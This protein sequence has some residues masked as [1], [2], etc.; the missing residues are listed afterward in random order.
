MQTNL[1]GD[2][3]FIELIVQEVI[4]RVKRYYN[5]GLLI[6]PTVHKNMAEE[7]IRLISSL[8]EPSM[9]DLII[10]KEFDTE[11]LDVFVKAGIY[12][13]KQIPHTEDLDFDQ[14]N[15]VVVL[16]IDAALIREVK[17]LRPYTLAGRVLLKSL[18]LE[19][20]IHILMSPLDLIRNKKS[21]SKFDSVVMQDIQTLKSW[22]I[23]F[24]SNA[25]D[26]I[27][28]NSNMIT[29]GKIA[30]YKNQK[31]HLPTKAVITDMAIERA[32][33]N[34]IILVRQEEI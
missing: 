30:A 31:I 15:K 29:A 12:I 5:H 9:F 4:R 6:I 14:Y 22:G 32:R 19:K 21:P 11:T 27:Y 3:G 24:S 17:D 34:N 20:N 8:E 33:K 16:N 23:V 1:I 13:N 2:S 25:V 7:I 18:S 26:V 10:S 28:L